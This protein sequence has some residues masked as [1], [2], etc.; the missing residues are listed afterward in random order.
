MP[1]TDPAWWNVALLLLVLRRRIW[2]G[3]SGGHVASLS[4]VSLV[5]HRPVAPEL[6]TAMHRAVET[7]WLP[8]YG[9]KGRPLELT[10]AGVDALAE[11]MRGVGRWPELVV[12]ARDGGRWSS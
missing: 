11:H 6:V 8:G 1:E 2:M 9:V 12:A 4:A 7:G 10:D 5:A 3:N